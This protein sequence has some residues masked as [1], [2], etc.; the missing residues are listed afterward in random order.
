VVSDD[1][2]ALLVSTAMTA[3]G[4]EQV[5]LAPRTGSTEY[6]FYLQALKSQ[7]EVR[8]RVRLPE[9]DEQQ[10]KVTMLPAGVGFLRIGDTAPLR[11]SA[12]SDARPGH[13]WGKRNRALQRFR[14]RG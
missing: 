1:P 10:I 2:S 3:R 6:V 9:V 11:G 5:T 14:I 12:V 13:R 8:V 7:G 4:S